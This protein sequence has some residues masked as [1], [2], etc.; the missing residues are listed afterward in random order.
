MAIVILLLT[1]YC[2]LV[3]LL[4]LRASKILRGLR[5]RLGRRAL[6]LGVVPAIEHI[7]I[8][9]TRSWHTIV[10]IGANRGQ[11]V[12][13]A[14]ALHPTSVV[15]SFEPLR[16]PATIFEKIF[17][18]MSGVHLHRYA[19]GESAGWAE[20]NVSARDD[21]SSLLRIS[22]VQT[23][24]F[25]GTQAVATERVEIRTLSESLHSQDLVSPALLKIDVQGYEYSVLLGC[26]A[27]LPCFD[28][29]CVE[30]SFVELYGGQQL[31]DD[32]A[33]WLHQR[34][35]RMTDIGDL[36]RDFSGTVVQGDFL[37]ERQ[38]KV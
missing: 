20:M 22:S 4:L 5:S 26:E 16:G 37:F 21:S 14:I 7:R 6:K 25:P 24:I 19:I 34:G 17:A 27:L 28:A 2:Y 1:G 36:T 13:A 31:F 12:L 18:D 29:V 35:F 11:F 23:R 3:K 32:I 33:L 30:C 10:D 8:L 15:H 9:R 38:V